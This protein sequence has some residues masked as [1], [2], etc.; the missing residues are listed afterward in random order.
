MKLKGYTS[1]FP[2]GTMSMIVGWGNQGRAH[3]IK[4]DIDKPWYRQSAKIKAAHGMRPTPVK[5]P[6]PVPR[7]SSKA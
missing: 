1:S 3:E 5:R 6:R 2:S 4:V 7:R